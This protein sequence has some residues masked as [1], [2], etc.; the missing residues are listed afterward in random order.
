MKVRIQFASDFSKWSNPKL[1][2]ILSTLLGTTNPDKPV[3]LEGNID[4][5]KLRQLGYDKKSSTDTLKNIY[6]Y[7]K[8]KLAKSKLSSELFCT[9][10]LE[11]IRGHYNTSINTS[12]DGYYY[13]SEDITKKKTKVTDKKQV[14]ELIRILSKIKPKHD[15]TVSYSED[16]DELYTVAVEIYYTNYVIQLSPYRDY[17]K[18]TLIPSKYAKKLKDQE[19]YDHTEI[20][21]SDRKK[22]FWESVEKLLN[23][24]L[25]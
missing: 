19:D 12:K 1:V 3:K 15:A 14:S 17:Y 21:E 6:N 24:L 13:P 10:E 9:Y 7:C 4:L 23:E 5:S 22:V 20:P 16:N 11:M 8:N 18:V 25:S 2:Q